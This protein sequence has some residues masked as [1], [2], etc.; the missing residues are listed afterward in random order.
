MTTTTAGYLTLRQAA[1]YLGVSY[2]TA[3]RDWPFWTQHGVKPKRYKGGTRLR[4]KAQ[5]LDAMMAMWS[6]TEVAA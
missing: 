6:V 2:P 3:K 4:F 1:K 5:E